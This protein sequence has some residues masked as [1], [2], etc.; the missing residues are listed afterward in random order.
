M[1]NSVFLQPPCKQG[2]FVVFFNAYPNG[3]LPMY[4]HYAAAVTK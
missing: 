1:E 3:R 4:R 2:K